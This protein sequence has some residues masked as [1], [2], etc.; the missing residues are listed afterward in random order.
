MIGLDMRR[1]RLVPTFQ[2]GGNDIPSSNCLSVGEAGVNGLPENESDEVDVVL[3][4]GGLVYRVQL[5]RV[6]FKSTLVHQR[7][8]N[9]FPE[10][11]E[12]ASSPK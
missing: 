7:E 9:V 4:G 3:V 5:C 2:A 1:K 10:K 12:V 8:R 11:V 6:D